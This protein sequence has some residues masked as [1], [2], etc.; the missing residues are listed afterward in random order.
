MTEIFKEYAADLKRHLEAFE[1]G[2]LGEQSLMT[3]IA[4]TL[5]HMER[6]S[7]EATREIKEAIEAG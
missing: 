7:V 5:F 6:V 3:L 1:E 2:E 4:H